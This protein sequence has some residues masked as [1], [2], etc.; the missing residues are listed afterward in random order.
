MQITA[1]QWRWVEAAPVYAVAY[2]VA[3]GVFWF[4]AKRKGMASE[5]MAK[6]MAAGLVGG[7]I[8][9]NLMQLLATAE[10]GKTI[11]GGIVGGWLA[12]VWAKRRFGVNRPTGDLFA[13]AIPA[14]E[15]IGRIGCFIGGCCFG[16]VAHGLPWA[17]YG[18][19]AWRHPS[20]IYLSIAAAATLA[21][22]VLVD[23]RR[24]LPPNGLFYL[25]GMLFC[26]GRFTIDFFREAPL[27]VLGL[28]TSQFACIAGFAV[29]AFLFARLLRS[30]RPVLAGLL[31][32]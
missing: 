32:A 15:A 10:P 5:A 19:G 20:Q 12:V 2:L 18:E 21:V 29:F 25:Q 4:V 17:V 28:T 3:V 30:P 9:A 26:T 14:G 23:R 27:G 11:E 31:T 13:F 8:G 1:E 7:L 6:V 22:L 24:V 16:R